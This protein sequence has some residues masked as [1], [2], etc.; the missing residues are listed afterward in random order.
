MKK[1][2]TVL[3]AALL[4][5]ISTFANKLYS[6]IPSKILN[7]FKKEFVQASNVNWETKAKHYKVKFNL[8]EQNIEAFYSLNG[9]LLGVTRYISF[10][11]LPLHLQKD[12]KEKYVGY[13]ITDLFELS[14]DNGTE[15]V[16][17][18]E[19]GFKKISLKGSGMNWEI[20]Q[21]PAKS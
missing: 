13:S 2:I 3:A 19:K 20:L 1:Q 14:T 8:N 10:T 11:Q 16:I 4:L 21:I 9:N 15:Y 17:S 5:T 6:D 12:I 7:E 18:F